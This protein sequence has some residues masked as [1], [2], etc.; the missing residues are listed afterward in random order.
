[1]L[2]PL[3]DIITP[4]LMLRLMSS[5]V[6]IAC[7][8]GELAKAEDQLC[9][10]IPNELLNSPSGLIYT[11]KQLK[12]DAAYLPWSARAIILEETQQMI[13]LIRFHSCPNPVDLNSYTS[14]AAELGYRIFTAYRQQKY[15]TEAVDAI[16]D[17]AYVQFGVNR[18][19]ASVSPENKPS[20]R[21]ISSF[22][23][24]KVDEVMDD[25][26]GIEHVFL[27]V[28]TKTPEEF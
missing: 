11:Q 3:D 2:T 15:A 24:V 16:M 26:D 13:G 22:G 25:L 20:F 14:G 28:S 17:W 5:D 23:F 19:I 8:A 10:T 6:I 9:A 12:A 7:L 21:L 4:R 27:R 1:M 18:F